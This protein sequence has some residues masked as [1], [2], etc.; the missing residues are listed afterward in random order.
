MTAAAI[1]FA[2]GTILIVWDWRM[3]TPP[4]PKTKK[5]PPLTPTGSTPTVPSNSN[6]P[7]SRRPRCSTL[8]LTNSQ[9]AIAR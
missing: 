7:M 5:R 4:D 6:Y 9:T 2:I 3:S 1:A 8:P